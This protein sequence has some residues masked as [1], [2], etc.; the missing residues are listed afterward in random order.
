MQPTDPAQSQLPLQDDA[1]YYT[2]RMHALGVLP[3]HN[4]IKIRQTDIDPKS[5]TQGEEIQVPFPIFEETEKGIDILVYS[6]NRALIRYAGEGSRW[7]HHI[8]KIA[9]LEVPYINKNGD[10]VKYLMPKGQATQPFFPPGLIAHYEKCRDWKKANPGQALPGKLKIKALYMTEG[11]FKAFKAD[12]HNIY[13]VGLASIT[14]MKNKETG[15]L[16]EDIITLLLTCEVERFIWL[17]DGDCRDISSKEITE[18]KDLY[19]RPWGFFRSISTFCDLLSDAKFEDLIKYFAHI[20]TEALAIKEGDKV[21]TPGPKGLDDLLCA[22]PDERA[23]IVKEFADFSKRETQGAFEGAYLYRRNISYGLAA[24]RRYMMV[25]DV[26]EF[27]LFHV[28]K[29]PDIARVGFKFNGSLYKYNEE[30]AKC[31]VEIPGAAERYF[32]VGDKYYEW[33]EIPNKFGEKVRTYEERKKETIK[34]DHIKKHKTILEHIEKFHSFCIVP[35]HLNYQQKIHNCFNQYNPISHTPEKGDIPTSMAFIKHIFGEQPITIDYGDGNPYT[36]PYYELGLDYLTILLR[37]PQRSLPI[38][39]LVSKENSTGKSTFLDWLNFIFEENMIQVGNEELA[40]PFNDFWTSKLIV[41]CDETKVDKQLVFEKIKRMSTSGTN[42]SQGK[43]IRHKV[44]D[45]FLHFI[46]C[47]NNE[48]S[49]VNISD[50]DNRFWVIKVP[51]FKTENVSMRDELRDEIDAFLYFLINRQMATKQRT[52]LW[53]DYNLLKTDALLRLI[54]NTKPS[55]ERRI[56]QEIQELFEMQPTA[57]HFTI[58]LDGLCKDIL[59]KADKN[60]VK[61]CL[62]DM[63]YQVGAT[64]RAA[65]PRKIEG[66]NTDLG[67]TGRELQ[68]EYVRFLGRAY[69]FKREDFTT[70]PAQTTT[71]T[72]PGTPGTGQPAP[73]GN[74]EDLPF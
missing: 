73:D 2:R 50:R 48:T 17:M 70:D 45:S 15:T 63:D 27:Y 55:M 47:S 21:I 7:K 41:G 18:G 26:D 57:D 30:Q 39:C 34:D 1:S 66:Y 20:N 68:V 67:G 56:R 58:P 52:R 40:N 36:V 33:V 62:N 46:F 64:I 25:N 10:E 32:R 38:L 29:R 60:Y 61:R 53:F 13:C 49:F 16:H 51:A 44:V 31:L 59:A 35:D 42:I 14:C 43:G 28:Q 4:L 6:L 69:T 72:Q 8:Y 37:Y 71:Q 65:Y 3:E 74:K 12:M 24:A 9:R 11:Y 5:P 23:D 54:E 19:K 22:L